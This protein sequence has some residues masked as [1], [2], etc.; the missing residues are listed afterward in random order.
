MSSSTSNPPRP[1]QGLDRFAAQIRAGLADAL[2]LPPEAISLDRPR[3]PKHGEY[4]FPCFRLAKERKMAPPALAT[5]LEEQLNLDGIGVQRVGP[6]LNFRIEPMPLAK[7]V[8]PDAASEGFGSGQEEGTILVEYSSPNIA[9]PMHIG[10]LRTTV[11]GAAL[12]RLFNHLGHRVVRINHVGDWGSQFG[13]LV[14]AW[15]RWGDPDQ[16]EAEPIEHL[17]ELY[18][19]YHQEEKE[20]PSLPQQ[21]REVF[22]ELE[23]GQDNPTRQTWRQFTEVSLAAFEKV[24]QRLNTEFDFVRGESWYEDRLD[25]TLDF[26]QQQDVLELSEGATIVDLSEQGI[27]TPCLV[28]TA[29]GTTLY[30][31]RDIAAALSRW[32]EFTFDRCLYVVGN[33][34][35]LHFQQL[36]GVLRKAGCDFADRIEHI[37]FGLVRFAEGKLST[38]E[39]RVLRLSEVLD[40][41]VELA[42]EVVQEKNPEHPEPHKVAE[43]VGIGAVLFHDLKHLR[44]KD[45]V[46][47]WKEVLSFEGET[48]PYLQYSRVRTAA[49]LRKAG[50]P[51]PEVQTIDYQHVAEARDLMVALGR[52]PIALREAAEKREPM[53]LAQQLLAVAAAGNAFYRD[54]RVLGSGQGV[55]DARLVVVDAIRRTLDI[56]LNI[57][58]VPIPE[59]M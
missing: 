12:S 19:R 46:F 24:Y 58:G 43:Q 17:L 18:V 52:F 51:V 2:S 9:K 39:G 47:N 13:K 27:K 40:R 30:A 41:A 38:R 4:A 11:L 36:I 10:H 57:L 7:A 50:R 34:Q 31:T 23:S 35:K 25:Q 21:A 26:L 20:D 32:Q 48:G 33:E 8:L 28:K 16:L 42:L 29:H 53:I 49:I 45:V 15:N 54:F 6:F 37:S 5:W 22:L 44:N 14:A 56:G 1:A 59:T 55:E 3:D